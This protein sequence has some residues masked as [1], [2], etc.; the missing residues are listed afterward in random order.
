MKRQL[1]NL[2]MSLLTACLVLLA[3]E[4]GLRLL[5]LPD[6]GLYDGDTRGY[7]TLRASMPPREVLSKELGTHFSVRTSSARTRG[8]EPEPGAI[9]CLGDSTT[10]G[11]AVHEDEAWPARLSAHLGRPVTNGGV[12]GYSTVQGL[13]FLDS[14]LA[15]R[16]SVVVL[17]FLVRDAELSFVADRDRP[18]P[19]RDFQLMKFVRALRPP[20]Q[21]GRAGTVPRVSPADYAANVVE[22]ARRVLAAGA[23]PLVLAFPMLEPPRAHLDALAAAE[24]PPGTARLAPELP[25][26]AFF[27]ADPIHLTPAG[28]D[29][30]AQAVATA[31]PR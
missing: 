24:L 29:L 27:A 25:P 10:F 19:P 26:G 11:W 14:V 7:W 13:Q 22:L 2:A 23:R 12:P 31:V 8:P 15:T 17:G 16:P 18:P 1:R 3:M 9:L 5:G 28:N 4:G 21:G 30:L 20:P 6:P